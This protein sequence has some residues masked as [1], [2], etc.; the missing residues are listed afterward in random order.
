MDCGLE[1]AGSRIN[2]GNDPWTVG[3]REQDP[4]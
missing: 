2:V 3:L 1:R 4:L